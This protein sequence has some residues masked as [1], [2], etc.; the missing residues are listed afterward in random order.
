MRGPWVG[1]ISDLERLFVSRPDGT[2]DGDEAVL[3]ERCA[4]DVDT[5]GTV[6][7]NTVLGSAT[8]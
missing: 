8:H 6:A 4:M 3:M 5:A 2:S 1:S 7:N